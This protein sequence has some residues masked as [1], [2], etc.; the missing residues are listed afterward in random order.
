MNRNY[1]YKYV[2]C[3]KEREEYT[4]T[5]VAKWN[6]IKIP[7]LGQRNLFNTKMFVITRF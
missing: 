6:A 5:F 7:S 1:F 2:Y 4:K 3:E